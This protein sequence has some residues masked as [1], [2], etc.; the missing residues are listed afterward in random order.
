[1][2][3]RQAPP[4]RAPRST[5][6]ISATDQMP[7]HPEQIAKLTVETLVANYGFD[8]SKCI[9]AVDSIGDPADLEAAV[10]WLLDHG[11]EDR[12]GAVSLKRCPHAVN[13]ELVVPHSL[14][15]DAPCSDGCPRGENWI[16]LHCGEVR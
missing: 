9:T 14:G 13:A 7:G 4:N 15:V 3:A 11:E 5:A 12:G 6:D 10:S 2:R 8:R 16:C 1:M